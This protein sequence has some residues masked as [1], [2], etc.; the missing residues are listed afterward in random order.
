MKT[1]ILGILALLCSLHAVAQA[2]LS[3][4]QMV[5]QRNIG[6]TANEYGSGLIQMPS[7][8]YVLSTTTFSDSTATFNCGVPPQYAGQQGMK[9]ML[10]ILD[11]NGNFAQH[12]CVP[13]KM[14]S[15]SGGMKIG[16][17]HV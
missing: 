3:H 9:M 16:R 17:A 5:W 8:D 10:S 13:A 1:K 2:P 15:F 7:G 6:G 14:Y 12:L 4:L 11:S